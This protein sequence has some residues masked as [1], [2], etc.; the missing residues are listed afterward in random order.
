MNLEQA[1][2]RYIVENFLLGEDSGLSAA[3]SLLGTGVV[4]S[5]GILELVMFLE[6]SYGIEVRDEEMLPEN[7]DSIANI[8]KFVERKLVGRRVAAQSIAG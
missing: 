2:R 8:V 7:L 3:E 4:D 1:V 5:T 6:E